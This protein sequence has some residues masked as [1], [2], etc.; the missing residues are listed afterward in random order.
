MGDRFERAGVDE[1]GK[2]EDLDFITLHEEVFRANQVDR[3][4]L[5]LPANIWV[6]P[7]QERKMEYLLKFKNSMHEQWGWKDPRTCLLADQYSRLIPQARYLIIFKDYSMVVRSLIQRQKADLKKWYADL[8]LLSQARG[9]LHY[10]EKM[11]RISSLQNIYLDTWCRY[12]QNLLDLTL[13]LSSENY[14]MVNYQDLKNDEVELFDKLSGEWNFD[15]KFFPF[16][17]DADVPLNA[18]SMP[19]I[20]FDQVIENRAKKIT[21]ALVNQNC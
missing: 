10:R 11:I 17:T 9:Y 4:G 6:D 3:M 2:V 13:T 19:A 7:Y 16:N 5:F 18:E 14:F 20:E 21:S 12:Y 15:L 8:D 1:Q